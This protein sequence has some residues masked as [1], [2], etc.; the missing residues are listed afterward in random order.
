MRDRVCSVFL[1]SGQTNDRNLKEFKFKDN[2]RRRKTLPPCDFRIQSYVQC[3]SHREFGAV[4]SYHPPVDSDE[5][6]SSVI[7]EV[8]VD[9]RAVEIWNINAG[10]TLLLEDGCSHKV[11]ER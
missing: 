1:H 3:N 2:K 7:L 10:E 4:I 5:Y 11:L 6:P 9:G 8:S